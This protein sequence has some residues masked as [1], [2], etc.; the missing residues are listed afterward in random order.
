M[1]K[2]SFHIEQVYISELSSIT[3]RTVNTAVKYEARG[4]DVKT[5]YM[6]VFT[7]GWGVSTFV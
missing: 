1:D 5:A 7:E 6:E 2:E 3:G 4:S